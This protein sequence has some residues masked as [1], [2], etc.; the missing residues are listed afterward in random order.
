MKHEL[1][2]RQ[3]LGLSITGPFSRNRRRHEGTYIF[4][5][6]G[7]LLSATAFIVALFV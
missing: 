3:Q 7:I 1:I 6:I 5:T 4:L 2:R